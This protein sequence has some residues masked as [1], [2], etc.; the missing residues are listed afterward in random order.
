MPAPE[1]TPLPPAPLRSQSPS[2]F[3]ATAEAFVDALEDLPGEI[4]ALAE[5]LEGL[6]GGTLDP[7]LAAIAALTTAAFGRGLL[8]AEDAAAVLSMLGISS[9]SDEQARDTL[10]AALVAGAGLAKST[11]DPGD[12]IT[13]KIAN[14]GFSFQILGTA[15]TASEVL[16]AWSP[17]SGETVT[18]AD[19]FTGCF[20]LKISGGTNPGATYAMDVKKNGVSVGTISISTSGV[21]SFV[22]S[23]TTVALIGGTDILTIHG[24]ATPD[25]TAVGYTFTMAGDL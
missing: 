12:T 14:R 15:P 1:I 11:D 13:F 8:E 5:Y 6:V 17:R 22:T 7:D 3:T 23:E 18:F 24:N 4:N 20:G 25:A 10:A 2:T 21:V 19:D 9:Y 16:F